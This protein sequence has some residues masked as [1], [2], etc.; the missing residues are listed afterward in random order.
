MSRKFITALLLFS[1]LVTSAPALAAS[2]VPG[3]SCPAIG[4]TQSTST[5][6]FTCVAKKAKKVW[7]SGVPIVKAYSPKGF[8]RDRCKKDLSAEGE[9]VKIQDFLGAKGGCVHAIKIVEAHLPSQ[10]PKSNESADSLFLDSTL[11]KS[12]NSASSESWKGFPGQ[13]KNSAFKTKR[14]PSPS[15]VM[16]VIPIYSSDAPKGSTTPYQ[17]YKYYFDFIKDYFSYI[18][19]SGGRFEL[20]VPEAYVNF[21]NKIADYGIRHAKDDELS[22]NFIQDV[23]STVDKDINFN[24]INFSLVIVPAGTPSGV[25][26]QQGFRGALSSEGQITNLAVSQPATYTRFDNSV[27]SGSVSPM[28]WLHEFYH[29]GLNLGDNHANN[30]VNYDDERGMGDFGLMSNVNGD[31]L[32]WQKWI[33]GFLT[34]Q[35]IRCVSRDATSTI[36]W[37]APSSLK[38]T[39]DKLLVIPLG[40]S[41]SI[42]VESIRAVGISYKY[43]AESLGALVY[44]VDSSEVRQDYGY[45]VMYPDTRRPKSTEFAMADAPLK[46][47]ESV[48]IEGYKITNIE[49]G[50]FGDVLKVE[51]LN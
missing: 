15:T 33:L 30:S 11:C 29:P 43:P 28:V 22:K 20:R 41:K 38:S 46:L 34:D 2:P 47:G 18:D 51:H 5:K 1:M 48:T 8:S 40:G 24:E 36:S 10:R 21:P 26:G 32:A 17:D 13:A 49:W 37:L 16:Q 19:D 4:K 6:K 7:N 42:V 12:E 27:T 9:A 39:R 50:D 44:V 31:L 25:I 23:I 3:K 35:Q 14:H 45:N